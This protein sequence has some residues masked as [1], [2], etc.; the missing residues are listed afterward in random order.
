MR[1]AVGGVTKGPFRSLANPNYRLWAGGSLVSN[2]GTWF[3]RI[4]QDWLVL[5]HLTHHS[6]SAVGLVMALQAAPTLLLLP[7]TGVAADRLERRTLLL[8]SQSALAV[9]ALGLGLLTLTNTVALW[10]VLIIALLF[11]CVTAFDSPVRQTFAA[12]LVGDGEIANAVALNSTSFN[13]ARMIGPA[14]AGSLIAACGTGWAFV[15]N[16][17]SFVAVL[18]SLLLLRTSRLHPQARRPRSRG[19][20]AEG[21]RYVWRR[22]DLHA[23]MLMTF[24]IGTFGLNFPIFISTMAV[25]VF[26]SGAGRYG[27]LMSVMA[28]G[29]ILGALLSGRRASPTMVWLLASSAIF[30]VGLLIA[31]ACPDVWLFGAALTIVGG[32]SVAFTT[33]TSSFMQIASEGGMRGRVASLRLAL[34]LGATPVGAPVMGWAADHFSPRVALALGAV[35]GIVAAAVGLQYLVRHH[36]L[37]AGPRGRRLSLTLQPSDPETLLSRYSVQGAL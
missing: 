8:V 24:L 20:F 14:L 4:A 18:C 22:P 31:S 35:S 9:L 12:E 1:P 23:V 10:Q 25:T 15:V 3:Q 28:L 2:I 16:G 29:S 6:A 17:A 7:L 36:G 30:G 33:S 11:G 27:S 37:R 34:G 19:Q 32:S 21:F 26:R 5:T 13:L